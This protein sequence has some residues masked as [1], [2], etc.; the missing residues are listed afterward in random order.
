MKKLKFL[1]IIVVCISV[2]SC[3]TLL[4]PPIDQNPPTSKLKPPTS[5]KPGNLENFK[6]VYISPTN[7]LSSSTGYTIS[8]QYYSKSKSV[9]PSDVIAGILTKE[10]FIRLPELKPELSDETVIVNYGESG[11]RTTGFGG[12]AI[13]VTIQLISA[14]SSTL[15]CSCTAEGQGETEVDDIRQAVTRCLTELIPKRN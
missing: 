11:K 15:I 12:Y 14:K 10:G 4:F 8:G 6:Y 13:E 5:I 7:I 1:G 2:I 9:N 3:S